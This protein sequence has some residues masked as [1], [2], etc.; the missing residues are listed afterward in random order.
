VEGLTTK[1]KPVDSTDNYQERQQ[2]RY[3]ERQIRKWK[4]REVAAMTDDEAKKAKGY[5]RKW[6]GKQR[7]LLEGTGRYRKYERESITQA[8]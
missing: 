2:Q 8:R 6:Q 4:R 1:P 3:N 5:I 7:K